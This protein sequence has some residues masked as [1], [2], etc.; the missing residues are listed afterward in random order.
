MANGTKNVTL[1]I[2]AEEEHAQDGTAPTT[3]RVAREDVN[4]LPMW[5]SVASKTA[6]RSAPWG[7]GMTS[8]LTAFA[9]DVI[10]LKGVRPTG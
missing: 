5:P 2:T 9:A 1:A 6:A 4:A 3:V 7:G 8:R 10:V